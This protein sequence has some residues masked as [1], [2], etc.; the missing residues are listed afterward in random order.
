M[1]YNLRPL[2]EGL[3][4]VND[5]WRRGITMDRLVRILGIPLNL[6]VELSKVAS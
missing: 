5:A 1:T 6:Q 4:F 2:L 3:A